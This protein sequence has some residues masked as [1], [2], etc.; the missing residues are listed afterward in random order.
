[1]KE[2]LFDIFTIFF[3]LQWLHQAIEDYLVHVYG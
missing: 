1:M 3:A 2:L